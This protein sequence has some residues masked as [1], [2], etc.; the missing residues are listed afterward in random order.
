MLISECK[1]VKQFIDWHLDCLPEYKNDNFLISHIYKQADCLDD[2]LL[3]ACYRTLLFY[4]LLY[5]ENHLFNKDKYELLCNLLSFD[6]Y[7]FN[8]KR[9][10]S[11]III[12]YQF[13][14]QDIE[15]KN[16]S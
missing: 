11:N 7:I 2:D 1:T 4:A 13:I 15:N 9:D 12:A 10:Y 5:V 14:K 6:D 16:G 3:K 8:G